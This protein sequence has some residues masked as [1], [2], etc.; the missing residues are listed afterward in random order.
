[1]GERT[2]DTLKA[3][4]CCCALGAFGQAAA[5]DEPVTTR[6]GARAAEKNSEAIATIVVT[7]ERR[8]QPLQTVPMAIQ[9][10]S[11]EDLE[12][13]GV[14]N[15]MDLQGLSPGVVVTSNSG[16]GQIY[17][18]GI[19]SDIVGAGLD[20]A[21]AV[22]VDGVYQSRPGGQLFKFVDVE[23]VEVMKGPQGTLYGRNATGGA[24]NII[25]KGPSR[26]SEGQFDVQLGSFSQKEVRGTVSGPLSA[27][28]AYGRL[29]LLYS[30]DDG[31]SKN[32][33]LNQQGNSTDTTGVRGAVEFTPSPNLTVLLNARYT[34]SKTAPM[35]N[36]LYPSVNPLFTTFKA[37]VISDPFTVM[38]NAPTYAD[39]TQSALDATIKYNLGWARFTSVTSST[40]LKGNAYTDID[41]TEIPLLNSIPSPED[42]RYW[43]QDFTLA[44]SGSGPWEWT[45]LASFLHQKTD[46]NLNLAIPL[47]RVVSKNFS[48]NTNDAQGIG[49]QAS[50]SL[51]NGVKL[52]AGTRYSSET[53][54]IQATSITQVGGVSLPATNQNAEQT[55]TAWT[56]KFVAEYSPARGLMWFASATKGFKS[57]GYN[58]ATV[59]S[60][61]IKPETVVNYEAGVK[62]A[63]LNNRV[64][65]NAT[66][67][68]AKYDEMQLQFT[69]KNA[70]GAL[71]AVTT[72]AAK[73]TSKGVEL[74]V[75]AKPMPR[76]QLAAGAQ[77]LN[78]RFD[79]FLAANPLKLA[80]GVLDQAGNPLNRS[81]DSTF[82]LSAQYTWP[83]AF[84][85]KDVT[86]RADAYNRSRIYY[87]TFKDPLASEELGTL[88]NAQLSFEPNGA[89]GLYGAL[90]VKN[91]TDKKHTEDILAS[92]T[93]GYIAYMAAPR[94][95][96]VKIGYRY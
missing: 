23:R 92:S 62:S 79:R 27:G 84:A 89:G 75:V 50:Y 81:P 25:S 14:T 71:V 65:F 22:Y 15:V 21:V 31:Y 82:N 4:V 46:W 32:T 41:G 95:V 17:V 55:W 54:K 66:A 91:M 36:A 40:S 44:S 3:V 70:A 20:G 67:F 72:N 93:A 6:E 28:V 2:K 26:E 7:A 74:E 73:A 52:T 78:A 53:K 24:I 96:G 87:T 43:T 33:L 90:F 48:S 68:E 85:G 77:F 47:S 59:G 35:L 83:S 80:A 1:M 38:H 61:A 51:G 64:I 37:T 9:A 34:D 16:L 56:P 69:T 39:A 45:A 60:P 11:G 57:G 12:R 86:L 13:A 42:T 63:W 5:A 76:L 88:L 8:A 94:T 10:F 30:K 29:S 19:G 18:R 58:T 49:G